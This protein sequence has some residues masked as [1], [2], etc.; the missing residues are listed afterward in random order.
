M[1]YYNGMAVDG[2]DSLYE[3]NYTATNLAGKGDIIEV[4]ENDDSDVDTIVIRSYTFAMVE[5]ADEDVSS[6]QSSKGA[7]IALDLV[8]INGDSLGNGTY[9]DDYDDD[10]Y[11]LNGYNSDYSEGTA[12]AVAFGED[13]AILDSYAMEAVTGTLPPPAP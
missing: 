6:T 5:T 9:Y 2:D 3:D 4:Y 12:I 7:S 1:V 10:E 8:D 11:V 13:Y